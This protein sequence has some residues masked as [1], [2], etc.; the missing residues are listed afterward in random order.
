MEE[1]RLLTG[2]TLIKNQSIAMILKKWYYTLRNWKP[3]VI[4]NLVPI[5]F[6]LITILTVRNGETEVKPFA[7]TF[8][9]DMFTETRTY[10]E[11]SSFAAGAREHEII[12]QYKK[13]FGWNDNNYK[14]QSITTDIQRKVLDDYYDNEPDTNR[15]DMVGASVTTRNVSVYFNNQAFHTVPLTMLLMQ[16]AILKT[17]CAEC[18]I[19]VSNHPLDVSLETRVSNFIFL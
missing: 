8:K 7:L 18:E 10:L 2:G 12:N 14:L 6:L 13:V 19:S 11:T 16:N 17:F 4:V 1:E 15:L 9:M 3:L 5:V